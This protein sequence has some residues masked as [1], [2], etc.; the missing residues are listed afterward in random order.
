MEAK[1]NNQTAMMLQLRDE[2]VVLKE[3]YINTVRDD[4]NPFFSLSSS[5]HNSLTL[6]F[7]KA[8]FLQS[9]YDFGFTARRDCRTEPGTPIDTA[10]KC[11]MGVIGD[12]DVSRLFLFVGLYA[13]YMLTSRSVV[14][15]S[16]V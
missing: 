8:Y 13:A 16:L 14:H 10:I 1:L 11:A 15:D 6:F 9:A 7:D 4:V 2:N 3:R 5:I 12:N